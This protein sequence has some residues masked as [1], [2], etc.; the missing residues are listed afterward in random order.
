ME[1]YKILQVK[2]DDM[3]V[4][5]YIDCH[6]Q[7]ELEKSVIKYL[8]KPNLRWFRIFDKTELETITK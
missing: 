4:P 8:G 3:I 6:S 7:E 2:L 5:I 1:T